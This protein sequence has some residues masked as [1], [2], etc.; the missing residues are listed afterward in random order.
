MK[1][2]FL[3]PDIAY[4]WTG[5]VYTSW[6]CILKLSRGNN[7]LTD[8]LPDSVRSALSGE[9]PCLSNRLFSFSVTSL[10]IRLIVVSQHVFLANLQTYAKRRLTIL[11]VLGNS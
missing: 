10:K 5:V 2:I 7:V 11:S 8:L 6:W 1:E 4:L 3:D 9:K